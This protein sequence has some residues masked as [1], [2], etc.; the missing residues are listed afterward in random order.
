MVGSFGDPRTRENGEKIV[1]VSKD[2]C[3]GQRINLFAWDT[4]KIN[5]M[6][7]GTNLDELQFIKDE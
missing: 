3:L 5:R 7:N 2:N 1:C 6:Y 4:V